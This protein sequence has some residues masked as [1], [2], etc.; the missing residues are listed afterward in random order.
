MAQT[1]NSSPTRQRNPFGRGSHSERGSQ[2]EY[3]IRKLECICRRLEDKPTLQA[4]V[5]PQEV[6]E[7]LKEEQQRLATALN[8]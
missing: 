4:G 5:S 2:I 8:T 1:D 3:R 7:I 6:L